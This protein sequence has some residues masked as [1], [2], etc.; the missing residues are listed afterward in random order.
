MI[1]IYLVGVMYSVYLFSLNHFSHKQF[2]RT[3][4]RYKNLITVLNKNYAS[5]ELL[6]F[7]NS[8]LAK[9][10]VEHLQNERT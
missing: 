3:D 8:I 6:S 2:M 10:N 9:K 5:R 1:I 7:K 4:T